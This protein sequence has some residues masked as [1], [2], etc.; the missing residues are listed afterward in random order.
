MVTFSAMKD[1]KL[2]LRRKGRVL[3]GEVKKAKI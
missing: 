2:P 3:G 1:E